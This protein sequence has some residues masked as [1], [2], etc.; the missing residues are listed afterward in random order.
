MCILEGFFAVVSE[1]KVAENISL[2]GILCK[3]RAGKKI[4]CLEKPE[5]SSLLWRHVQPPRTECSNVQTS[6]TLL[7]NL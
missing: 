7:L 1:E 3:I 4:Q 2:V 6:E 5:V